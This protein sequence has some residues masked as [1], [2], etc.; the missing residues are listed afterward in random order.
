MIVPQTF[1]K[2][3]LTKE[4]TIKTERFTVSGRKIPLLEIRTRML[5]EHESLGLLRIQS[6][7][8]YTSMTNAEVRT[9]LMQLGEDATTGEESEIEAKERLKAMERKRHL[10]IWG[11]NSTLLNHGHLLLTVNSV[12]DEALYFTN[13]EMKANGKGDIDV[14]SVV[15]RPH[16]YILGRC[17]SSEVD[18]L[19]YI[20][21]RKDCLQSLDIKITT[22][23]GVEITDVVRFFHGDGPQQ[24]FEAG[25]QKGGNAGCASCSGDARMYK[26]L[27]VSFSRPHLTLSERLKKVLQGPAG[28]NKR[29]AGLKP[30]KD[31][32]LEELRDECRA[33]G[34]ESKGQ[35]KELQEIL[36]EEI[37]G[38]QR[39]P[40]MMFFDQEKKLAD[41]ALGKH[42]ILSNTNVVNINK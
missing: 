17:G 30:F 41:L 8:Y 6:D 39:V 36:K 10:M 2:V 19:A 12:Y 29:N 7:D 18:Q 3:L 24:Q 26:D 15:E 33:R 13:E 21:T 32:R 11:D 34:L 31:L 37:G 35:K 20:N 28:K 40:A 4:G 25:E 1:K 38:I 42:C 27:A 16:V 22:S 5:K 14:Q 23:N 9:R